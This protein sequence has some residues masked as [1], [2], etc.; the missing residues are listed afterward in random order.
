MMAEE[1]PYDHYT[2]A[3][4]DIDRLDR[5]IKEQRGSILSGLGET[6]E[7]CAILLA[8]AINTL[9][10]SVLSVADAIHENTNKLDSIDVE[11][12]E[13]RKWGVGQERG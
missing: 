1:K 8:S 4:A 3:A 5:T 12:T 10:L 13:I 11:V 6:Q 2:K 9:A 7:V